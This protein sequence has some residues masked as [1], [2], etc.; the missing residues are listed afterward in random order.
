LDKGGTIFENG[1][2]VDKGVPPCLTTGLVKVVMRY[3]VPR[4]FL[5]AGTL[6]PAAAGTPAAVYSG[7]TG[8]SC[9]TLFQRKGIRPPPF[10]QQPA[11]SIK[12]IKLVLHRNMLM[13]H[14]ADGPQ[15]CIAFAAIGRFA[16]NI[17][18]PLKTA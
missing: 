2:S 12:A 18:D 4:H 6:L 7:P 8:A 10:V 15:F 13:I 11:L 1:R 17:W 14:Q 16:P 9:G 3:Q 5:G